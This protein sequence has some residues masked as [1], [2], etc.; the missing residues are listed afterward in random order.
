M[1]TMSKD[2]RLSSRRSDLAWSP[3]RDGIGILAVGEDGDRLPD[4]PNPSRA[5][6]EANDAGN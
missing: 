2:A 3:A 4:A 6:Q 1:E 5:A